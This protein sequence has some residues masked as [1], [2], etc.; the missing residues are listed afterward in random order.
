MNNVELQIKR[1]LSSEG[2]RNYKQ[3][4]NSTINLNSIKNHLDSSG[5]NDF[6]R[7]LNSLNDMNVYVGIPQANSSRSNENE[8]ITNAELMYIHTNG[9]A[10]KKARNEIEKQIKKGFSGSYGSVREKVFQMF[11]MEHGSP[12]YNIPPRPVIE[13]AILNIKDK[14]AKRFALS[15]KQYLVGNSAESKEILNSIGLLAQANC[16]KWFENPENN[17]PPLAESTIKGKRRKHGANYDPVPLVDTGALRQSITY[18][19]DF[20]DNK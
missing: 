6:Y 17:W 16:Q 14:I 18:V 4:V 5:I 2:Y 10:K 12:A 15:F 1:S 19:V 13:P 9:T 7:R 20:P 3:V 11:I 8:G